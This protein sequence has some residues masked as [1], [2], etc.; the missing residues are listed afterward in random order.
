MFNRLIAKVLPH[1]IA[2]T[3]PRD[4]LLTEPRILMESTEPL[5]LDG[6]P[7]YEDAESGDCIVQVPEVSNG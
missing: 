4:P 5:V 2:L 6:I 3:H 7:E 1:P